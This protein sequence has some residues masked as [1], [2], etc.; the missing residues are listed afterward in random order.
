MFVGAGGNA[1]HHKGGLAFAPLNAL[2]ELEYLYAGIQH[3][4]TGI[5]SAVRDGDAVTQIGGG[6]QLALQH[7]VHV[8]GADAAGF[9]QCGGNLL[10]GCLL[11]AGSCAQVNILR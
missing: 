4:F 8:G 10:D 11:A 6:L 2:R 1:D 9:G 5:G 3:Q 7:A